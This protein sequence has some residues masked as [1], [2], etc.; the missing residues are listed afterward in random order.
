[1]FPKARLCCIVGLLF[2]LPKHWDGPLPT[3]KG[4]MELGTL[5]IVTV[6]LQ[7]HMSGQTLR[8]V[9]MTSPMELKV[10]TEPGFL[11]GS[12][13]TNGGYSESMPV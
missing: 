5:I 4:M 9:L 3:H 13:V 7:I 8:K 10:D 12:M 1:M 6:R 2:I 11:A